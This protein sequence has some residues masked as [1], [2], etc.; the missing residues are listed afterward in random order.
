MWISDWARIKGDWNRYKGQ[1]KERWGKLTDD[2][3]TR[4]AGNRDQLI[5]I[6]QQRY[7]LARER[8]EE[9]VDRFV[10]HDSAPDAQAS[11]TDRAKY[12]ATE[13]VHKTKGYFQGQ[14]FKQMVHDA[15]DVVRRNHTVAM[16]AGVG[17]GF[18][19]GWILSPR[20]EKLIVD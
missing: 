2:D 1:V 18:L 9:Q 13:F 19:L 17:V 11:W 12:R 6:L 4:I 5:G 7:G 14:N 3:L 20:R 16:A 10:G 8:I 15:E